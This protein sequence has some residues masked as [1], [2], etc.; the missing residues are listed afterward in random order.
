MSHPLCVALYSTYGIVAV[1]I[2]KFVYVF[3]VTVVQYVAVEWRQPAYVV[4]AAAVQQADGSKMYW[5]APMVANAAS[6]DVT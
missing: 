6:A 4:D 1:C 2:I 5:M 3:V